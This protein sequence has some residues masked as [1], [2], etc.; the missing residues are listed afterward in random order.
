M[1]IYRNQI[2]SFQEAGSADVMK[3]KQAYVVEEDVEAESE[4]EGC[5]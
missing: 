2:G 3:R 4:L 5:F 1:S